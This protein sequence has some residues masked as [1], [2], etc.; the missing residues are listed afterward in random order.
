MFALNNAMAV[1]LDVSEATVIKF[2]QSKGL[3]LEGISGGK[4]AQKRV[5]TG[6]RP[7]S[8]TEQFTVFSPP[9]VEDPDVEAHMYTQS[10][11]CDVLCCLSRPNGK[12]S[13][14]GCAAVAKVRRDAALPRRWY[15][16]VSTPHRDDCAH[17]TM[18]TRRGAQLEE[19][20]RDFIEQQYFEYGQSPSEIAY[21]LLNEKKVCSQMSNTRPQEKIRNIPT[22]MSSQ[23]VQS[24]HEYDISVMRHIGRMAHEQSTAR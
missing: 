8:A 24:W 22:G 5:F 4:M 19:A 11:N 20:G 18:G 13:S 16:E 6:G 12:G 2:L 17:R 14:E 10:N 9:Q 23:K 7:K 21:K 15:V 3:Q 1:V